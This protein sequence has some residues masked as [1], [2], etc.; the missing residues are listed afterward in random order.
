MGKTLYCTK[1]MI[2][3][4]IL[5]SFLSTNNV[6]PTVAFYHALFEN[7]CPHFIILLLSH[8]YLE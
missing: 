6:G 7:G 1:I 3:N 2:V 8:I 5:S 4:D